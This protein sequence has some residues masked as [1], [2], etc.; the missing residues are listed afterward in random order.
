MANP[1]VGEIRIFAGTFAP[2]GWMF[3]DGQQLPI[4]GE[5][6]SIYEI[7]PTWHYD[8]T[9]YPTES[10]PTPVSASVLTSATVAAAWII[11]GAVVIGAVA[12]A[13]GLPVARRVLDRFGF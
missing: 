12:V 1:L 11:E 8:P 3:C 9:F 4:P 6:G 13:L 10:C 5:L 7:L 2:A